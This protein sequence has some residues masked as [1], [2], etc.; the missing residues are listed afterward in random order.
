VLQIGDKEFTLSQYPPDGSTSSSNMA[1]VT[2]QT[3]ETLVGSIN[4]GSTR[5]KSPSLLLEHRV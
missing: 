3:E 4:P 2:N 1:A 5:T